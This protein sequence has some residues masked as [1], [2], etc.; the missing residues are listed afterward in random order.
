MR[1][2]RF[3]KAEDALLVALLGEITERAL[4]APDNRAKTAT[5]VLAKLAAAREPAPAGVSAGEL[6]RALVRT[7]RGKVIALVKPN[8][9]MLS[10]RA[11]QQNCTV[12]EAEEIGGWLARQ[13]WMHGAQTLDGLLFKW[14]SYLARA[15]HEAPPTGVPEGLDGKKNV[16]RDPQGGRSPG[17]GRRPPPGFG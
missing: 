8:W 2:V 17:A 11:T 14:P 16:G 9:A 12:R 13:G 4:M 15:R 10:R 1:G 5:A 6:E 3:T 7:S